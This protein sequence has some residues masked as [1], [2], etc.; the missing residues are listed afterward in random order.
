MDPIRSLLY[1]PANREDWVR[2]APDKYPADGFIFDLEDSIQPTAEAKQEAR[3]TLA[4]C[5]DALEA[6]DA[7][8]TVRVNGPSTEYIDDDLDAVVGLDV[9]ALLVPDLGTPQDIERLDHILGHL[10]RTRG[11][12][13]EVEIIAMA[14]DAYGL[15][16]VE[17]LCAASD[18]VTATVGASGENADPQRA[19]GYDFTR[20]GR[21]RQYLLSQVV[22]DGRAQGIEELI[23]GVWMDVDDLDGLRDEAEFVSQLGYTGMMVIHPSHVEVVNDVFTPDPDRVDYAQRLIEAYEAA[24]GTAAIRFEGDMVDTAHAKTAQKLVERAEAFDMID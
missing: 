3:E 20:E 8:V 21:E 13:E 22:M 4:A 18:R 24:E 19:V 23:A 14:E 11:V 10:E 7:T 16:H 1:V 17:E 5:A 12:D 6:T 15:N 9:D 2:G